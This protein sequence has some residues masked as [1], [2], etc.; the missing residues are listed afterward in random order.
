MSSDEDIEAGG[1]FTYG[2]LMA[3]ELNRAAEIRASVTS[4]RQALSKCRLLD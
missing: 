4:C 2:I 1:A 3:N